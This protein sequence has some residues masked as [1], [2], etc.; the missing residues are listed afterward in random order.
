MKV[1]ILQITPNVDKL[2]EKIGRVCYASED[3]ITEDSYK[4]FISGLIIKGHE[5]VL[6]HGVVTFS[7]EGISRACLSQ[8]TRHRIASYSV[9]SQRYVNEENFEY[10]I[11]NEFKKDAILEQEFINVME[12]LRET[13][14]RFKD[15]KIKNQDI[16]A[17]LPNACTTKL[18][19]TTNFRSLRNFFKERLSL[20]AQEEIKELATIMLNLTKEHTICFGDFY[21][22]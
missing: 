6:E 3:K 12:R 21:E 18:Y 5:S 7:I 8:L 16:R 2:I 4:T 11:P 13:Y 14:K 20:G 9:R 19:M 10:V 15:M 1:S 22:N 17:I